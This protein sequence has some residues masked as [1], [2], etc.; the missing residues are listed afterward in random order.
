M[1]TLGRVVGTPQAAPGDTGTEVVEAKE[2]DI[3]Q[4][5]K[6]LTLATGAF[7]TAVVAALDAFEVHDVTEP[8]VI[9]GLAVIAVCLFSASIV[10]AVDMIARAIVTNGDKSE[11]DD[12][13]SDNHEI[14]SVQSGLEVRLEGSTETRPVLAMR[15]QDGSADAFL[16]PAGT[17][18]SGSGPPTFEGPV[19][20][21][22][23]GEVR[24]YR[25][26]QD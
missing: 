14:G 10:M 19:R 4:Y 21:V 6:K 17:R 16:V 12:D 2:F 15:S 11:A 1:G 7:A 24:A 26:S 8:M 20:W 9:A 3:T 5:A 25:V 22:P 23:A 18:S 13:A